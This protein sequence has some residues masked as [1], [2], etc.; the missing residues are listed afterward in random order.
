MSEKE[1]DNFQTE[2][3]RKTKKKPLII[4]DWWVRV[5]N[6][7]WKIVS[8]DETKIFIAIGIGST[9]ALALVILSRLGYLD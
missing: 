8:K 1:P 5:A 7:R 3:S 4:R 9:I 2:F 6:V